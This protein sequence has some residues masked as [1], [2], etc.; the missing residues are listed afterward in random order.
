M[1]LKFLFLTYCSFY[2]TLVLKFYYLSSFHIH[3]YVV[4]SRIYFLLTTLLL[5]SRPMYPNF[6]QTLTLMCLLHLTFNMSKHNSITVSHI[7]SS[8][9]SV[10]CLVF[11]LLSTQL[12][13]KKCT[14]NFPFK[15]TS[16]LSSLPN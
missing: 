15:F 14:V 2:S 3:L 9:F 12:N 13:L 10:L 6:C 11:S 1:F 4:L 5:S 7:C 16:E 8:S